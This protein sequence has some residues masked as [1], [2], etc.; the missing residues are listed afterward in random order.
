MRVMYLKVLMM[1]LGVI[2]LP[3]LAVGEDKITADDIIERASLANYYAGDDGTAKIAMKITDRAGRVRTRE[4]TML[5][6]DIED[7]GEQRFYVYF[8]EPSDL[9][10]MVFMVDKKIGADDDRWLYVPAVDMV[11]RVA[12]KDKRSSFVG[13]HFTYEDVSG[14]DTSD[15]THEL[16]GI[17]TLNDREAYLIKNTPKDVASVEFSYYTAYIDKENFLA[18]K[19]EYY[20]KAGRLYRT[21][22]AEEVSVID[23]VPTVTKGRVSEVDGGETTVEFTD[24]RYDVGLSESIFTERYL[25]RPP[26]KWLK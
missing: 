24:V 4:L 18:L 1:L 5:R 6:L 16:V 12:A 13:S 7:G 8:R 9:T 20:D 3:S 2:F 22:T 17:E 21:V 15:D 25:R 23:G 19:A 11:K 26:R 10:G 14:R